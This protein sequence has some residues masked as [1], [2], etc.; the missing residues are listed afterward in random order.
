MSHYTVMIIGENP[1]KQLEPFQ[2]CLHTEWVDKSGEYKEEYETKTIPEFFCGSH[3]SWGYEITKELFDFIKSN[4][5]GAIKRYT[6]E[7]SPMHYLTRGKNYRGYYT[8]ENHKRC[9]GD[10]WFRVEEVNET[11]HPDKDICFEGLITIMVIKK[12]K[13][14]KINE[15]Y[16]DYD[17]YLENYHGITNKEE[18]GYW[19]NPNAK[20]DWHLLGGR[21]SGMIKLKE[22]KKGIIGEPG[23]FDN[24]IG[25]DQARKGDISNFSELVTHALIKDGKWYEK[26]EMGWWGVVHDEKDNW[27]E[28]FIKLIC[29]LP[30]DTLISI[31]DCHI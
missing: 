9:K 7:K 26:G 13:T 16:P 25:I 27:D 21:W 30:D 22:G 2:E 5:P 1:E 10:A 3:S 14:L 15:K 6:V 11:D 23:V 28:E 12:P 20:W 18:Q 17:T 4:K 24:N 31:Y 8:L 19:N 29:D